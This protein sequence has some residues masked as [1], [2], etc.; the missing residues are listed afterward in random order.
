MRLFNGHFLHVIVQLCA[1]MFARFLSI[2]SI[3]QRVCVLFSVSTRLL[4]LWWLVRGDLVSAIAH[5]AY[6]MDYTIEH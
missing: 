3:L 2:L 1:G 5:F 6:V 4:T